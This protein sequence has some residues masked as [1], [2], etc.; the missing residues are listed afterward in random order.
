MLIFGEE[1]KLYISNKIIDHLEHP[2]N[3]SFSLSIFV[4]PEAKAMR[5][6]SLKYRFLF[7][8]LSIDSELSIHSSIFCV[9]QIGLHQVPSIGHKMET[10]RKKEELLQHNYSEQRNRKLGWKLDSSE[11]SK[12]NILI[13]IFGKIAKKIFTS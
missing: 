6:I 5:W 4:N 10:V 7:C 8:G 12:V 1:L 2:L 3:E 9:Q 13:R 11:I